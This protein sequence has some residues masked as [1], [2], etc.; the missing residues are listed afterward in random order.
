MFHPAFN[1]LRKR[2]NNNPYL[3]ML[4]IRKRNLKPIK[5][6]I[7]CLKELFDI[8]MKTDFI[9]RYNKIYGNKL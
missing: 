9:Q 4:V 3:E 7:T 8:C 2:K 1:K 5:E 6:Q